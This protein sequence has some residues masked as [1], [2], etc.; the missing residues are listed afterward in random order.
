MSNKI[1][2][3]IRIYGDIVMEYKI[4]EERINTLV[5]KVSISLVARNLC[6]E[7]VGVCF[8]ITDFS[9]QPQN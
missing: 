6:N 9:Y 3:I 4:I 5:N 2:S 7:I 1:L 8:G